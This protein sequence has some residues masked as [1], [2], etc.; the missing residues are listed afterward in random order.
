VSPHLV[1][2]KGSLLGAVGTQL[3]VVGLVG[4]VMILLAMIQIMDRADQPGTA[5]PRWGPVA[6]L[7][8]YLA[9]LYLAQGPAVSLERR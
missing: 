7:G 5:K 9:G 3:L 2:G 8:T 6:M 1:H 4:V